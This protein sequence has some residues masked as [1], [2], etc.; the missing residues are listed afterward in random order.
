M[1]MTNY[2]FGVT[3]FGAPVFG[4]GMFGP[5]S[6]VFF[7]DDL[8]GNDGSPGDSP[9]AAVKTLSRGED[10]LRANRHD[11]LVMIGLSPDFT[12][13]E[14]LTW[15]KDFTHLVGVANPILESQRARIGTTAITTP[16]MNITAKGCS[17]R[18]MKWDH[19][20]AN[21]AALVCCQVTGGRNYF[22]NIHF[23]GIDNA[24]QDAAAAASL[25]LN[26]AEEN[27]FNHCTIG[28]DTTPRGTALNWELAFD[29]LATRNRFENCKFTAFL[30][31][32]THVFVK[33]IDTSGTDRV[34]IYK[35][36]EFISFSAN[37]AFDMTQ[38]FS[39]AAGG[40]TRHHLLINPVA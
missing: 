24:T 35:N 17:F 5:E 33:E 3:S 32:A 6:R 18:N 27:L 23:A 7:V 19:G 21:A 30:E 26:G 14:T 34:T 29:G 4:N 28:L 1:P 12:L 25:L 10:L 8:N 37:D 38:A 22:E 15:D 36:C 20:V 39:L 13:T 31:A 9:E 40:P 16:M 2:P 11:T